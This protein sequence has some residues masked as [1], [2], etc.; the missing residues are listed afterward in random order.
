MANINELTPREF[1]VLAANYARSIFPDY[2][3]KITKAVGD[4]NRDFEA[5]VDDL[6][7]WGEA[8]KLKKIRQ[9]YLKAD[10]ILLYYPLF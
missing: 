10:G 1:E 8:N 2:N 6:S 9:L 5:V 4:Y 3:W 7:K